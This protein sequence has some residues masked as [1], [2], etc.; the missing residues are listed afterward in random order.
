MY[1]PYRH[2]N[3]K[4]IYQVFNLIILNNLFFIE[5]IKINN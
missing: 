4:S 2:Y 3:L 1:I 5:V